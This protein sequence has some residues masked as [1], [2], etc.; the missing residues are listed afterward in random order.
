MLRTIRKYKTSVLGLVA[1]GL[2]ALAMSGFGVNLISPR[3]EPFAIKIDDHIVSFTDFH[4][5]RRD[6]EQRYRQIFGNNFEE[7]VKSFNI[8]LT[9]QTKEKIIADYLMQRFASQIGFYASN[10]AV[11]EILQQEVFPQGFDAT[12]YA[13]FLSQQGLTPAQFEGRLRER[14]AQLQLGKFIDDIS[15]ASLKETRAAVEMDETKYTVNYVRFDPEGFL[16][17]APQSFDANIE[18]YYNDHT[19]DFEAPAK[20]AFDY[21]VLDPNEFQQL[22][23]VSPDDIE[24]YYSDN[25]S[26]FMTP[27]EF[28]I[29]RIQFSYPA[30]AD[31]AK[32]ES[33]RKKAEE[34]LKKAKAGDPFDELAALNS[35]EAGA[36][37][38]RGDMG[39]LS[40][41]KLPKALET[42]AFKLLP[43]EVTDLIESGDALFIV[44]VE[45]HRDGR[46]Q[47]L[48][49][50]KEQIEKEIREREAPS[51]TANHAQELFDAFTRADVSLKDFARD[52]SLKVNSTV[53]LVEAATEISGLPDLPGKVLEM[54]TD[55][56]QLVD[57][58]EKSVLVQVTEYKEAAVQP[59]TEVKQKIADLLKRREASKLAKQAA[60][61]MVTDLQAGKFDSLKA[62]AAASKQKLEESKDISRATTN[63]P[64]SRPE[65]HSALFST[66][67][68][69]EKPSKVFDNDGSYF[70]F[71]VAA[72]TPPKPEDLDAKAKARQ[73]Q[74]N[75]ALAEEFLKSLLNK[76][77]AEAKIDIDPSVLVE[78]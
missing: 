31:A 63:A 76:L 56:K 75:R 34:V 28:K 25:L 38:T 40:K 23:Q 65:I 64:Y 70:V 60:E 16:K 22:V 66:F 14:A 67:K 26:Q 55:S 10:A 27:E 32:K 48:T 42:A 19:T 77:K 35:D 24:I 13:Y 12:T 37:A 39:W 45:D 61:T 53:G 17:D 73:S 46:Q 11:R 20:A 2:V 58:E 71:Q 51:W 36:A 69:M 1:I 52:H 74:E 33:V 21:A 49:E 9:E 4:N 8:N 57:V 15:F 29:R 6:L 5:E 3:T 30:G 47:E 68:A 7:L 72:V 43:G 78:Q 41:G 54:A 59:L 50:V 18:T 62:A 44:K